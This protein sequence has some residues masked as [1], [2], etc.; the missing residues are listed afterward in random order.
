[1]NYRH[2]FHAGNFADV[3]KHAALAL[4]IAH[5]KRK[6]APFLVLDTHA[7]IG[8]YDL[9]APEAEKTG[10]WK[11]GIGRV[12]A[13]AAVPDELAPYLEVVAG[14]NPEGGIRRYPGSPMVARRLMRAQ[15]RLALVELH[16]EDH[17]EL[18]RRFAGHARVGLHRMDGYAALT[19]LLPPPERRGVVLIDPPYE[20]RDELARLCRALAQAGRRWPTGIYLAWYPIKAKAPVDRFLAEL[21]MQGL[22]AVLAAE[23]RLRGG[24]DPATLNGCGLAVVNPPWQFDAAMAAMLPWLAD[25]LAPEDGGWRLDWVV[26]PA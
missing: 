9:A 20:D 21:A 18:A 25:T 6:E 24:D 2:A 1:M 7:G 16:P 11:G 22:P 17:G 8:V 23:I 10:E 14:L 19:A 15:D 3:V 5:L 4:V 26:R 13:A 12:L